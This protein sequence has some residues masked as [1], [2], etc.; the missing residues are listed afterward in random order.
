MKNFVLASV[1]IV[2][3]ISLSTHAHAQIQ[4]SATGTL[5][6]HIRQENIRTQV[7]ADRQTEPRT[8]PRKETKR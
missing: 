5:R 4:P 7:W 2:L 6:E 1:C 3:F 8:A